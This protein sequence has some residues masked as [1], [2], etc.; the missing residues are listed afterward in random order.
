MRRATG[1]LVSVA[2]LAVGAGRADAGVLLNL[3]DPPSQEL[4]PI[5][6]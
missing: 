6:L 3:E 1:L 5:A 2:L 4:T